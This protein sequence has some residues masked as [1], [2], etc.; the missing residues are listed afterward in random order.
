MPSPFPGMNPYLEHPSVW[1]D[2][3]EAFCPALAMLSRA[4]PTAVH[5]Q[6]RRTGV[7]ARAVGEER[8][9]IGRPDVAIVSPVAGGLQRQLPRTGAPAQGELFP[10]IDEERLSFL[11][12]RDRESRKLITVI[13]LLSPTNKD[14][15]GGLNQ[16]LGKARK[17]DPE[18]RQFRRRS[19]CSVPGLVLRSKH[20]PHCDY[21]VMVAR[22]QDWPK[23][24]LWPMMLRD[25]LPR[26]PIPLKPDRPR[27]G[28]RTAA[29]V[30]GIYDRAGYEDYIYTTPPE[31]PLGPADLAWANERARQA[32][33][34]PN[35]RIALMPNV[36]EGDLKS[37][38][39]ERFAIVVAR[40]N[41]VVTRKL[42]DGAIAT[43]QGTRR[44]RRPHHGRVGAG[45]FEIPLIADG[46]ARSG[47]FAAVIC[48]GAVVQG[49]T[50]HHK[51]INAE[52]SRAMMEIG[53]DTGNPHLVRRFD[54]P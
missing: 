54:L 32:R 11:E 22:P 13:E 18:R 15:G 39:G 34:R 19:T 7:P 37:A 44:R 36:I 6:D 31:P 53:I 49:E 48:L 33:R 14:A 21:Y 51:Y 29:L 16:Y 50:L 25:A 3:H 1:H 8:R 23:V 52:V 43:L 40:F 2:F 24:G 46:L 35:Q 26:I 10:S 28:D 47:R 30:D 42:L 9:L 12:I 17:P 5:R 41:D 45:S 20:L 38:A 27:R 4:R